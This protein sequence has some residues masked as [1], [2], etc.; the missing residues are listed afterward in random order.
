MVG[1]AEYDDEAS[2]PDI[3]GY[4]KDLYGIHTD[5]DHMV[6]LFGKVL[7]YD[8]YP[9]YDI[10]EESMKLKWTEKE[11]KDFLCERAQYL[12]DNILDKK[13]YD[14][15]IVITS[16]HGIQGKPHGTFIWQSIKLRYLPK[17]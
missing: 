6:H 2:E 9:K 17:I 13:K 14:G 8:I 16:C 5:I 12:E 15:L 7:N 3:N 1:I 4:L 11:L 10:E